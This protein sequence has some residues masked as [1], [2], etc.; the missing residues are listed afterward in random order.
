MDTS[1]TSSFSINLFGLNATAKTIMH[2]SSVLVRDGHG[3]LSVFTSES[4]FK[5][6]NESGNEFNK[7]SISNLF[8]HL[9][10]DEST[11]SV[12]LVYGDADL[13]R[14]ELVG[15]LTV[16]ERMKLL[17]NG[18]T[19][20]SYQVLSKEQLIDTS[21]EHKVLVQLSLPMEKSQL[22]LAY[23]KPADVV[24]KTA[25]LNYVRAY[26]QYTLLEGG[27]LKEILD[28]VSACLPGKP[29]RD[30]V[31]TML[32][33][34]Y[35][36]K[37]RVRKALNSFGYTQHQE[38]N[39]ERQVLRFLDHI[40]DAAEAM[41]SYM[42]LLKTMC[43]FPVPDNLDNDGA[44]DIKQQKSKELRSIN[45]QLNEM[46]A[47][48]A[49]TFEIN[50]DRVHPKTIGFIKSMQTLTSQDAADLIPTLYKQSGEELPQPI[51]VI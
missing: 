6:E 34:N 7:L 38:R 13:T 14:E 40:D 3:Q 12:N 26:K 23:G 33:E 27:Y 47:G 2:E 51:L 15:F 43:D 20:K 41:V 44:Q 25:V 9:A 32:T 42:K 8:N 48:T 24:F 28:V 36:R 45:N 21:E 11:V 39:V 1:L 19:E 10:S 49:N 22:A 35:S 18:M 5:K 4:R 30:V 17:T 29:L 37:A 46:V 16:F 50:L 31:Y